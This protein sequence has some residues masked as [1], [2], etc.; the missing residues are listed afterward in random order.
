MEIADITYNILRDISCMKSQG[1]ESAYRAILANLRNSIGRPYSQTMEVWRLMFEYLPEDVLGK[2][3]KLTKEEQAILNTLQLYSLHQ[4]GEEETVWERKQ[5]REN[6]GYSLSI[7]R[8][9]TESQKAT[10]RRFNTMIVSTHYEEF[11]NHLRQ[12]INL[13]KKAPHTIIDYPR[14]AE[15]LYRFQRGYKED[16]RLKWARAYYGRKFKEEENE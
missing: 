6:M 15:D 16:I 7:L 1:K 13:L 3:S 11:L 14:L 8:M 5:Y 10:D 9:D 4:Q 2:T 12:M